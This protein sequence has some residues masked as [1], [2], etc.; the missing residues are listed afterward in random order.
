MK[1][2]KYTK[3]EL[4]NAGNFRF[5]GEDLDES[6]CCYKEFCE[7]DY[8]SF[9]KNIDDMENNEKSDLPIVDFSELPDGVKY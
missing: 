6:I 5:I 9:V 4:I 8:I 3:T 1:N 7:G 2:K